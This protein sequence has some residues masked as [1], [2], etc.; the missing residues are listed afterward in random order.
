MAA[1]L[2][3]AGNIIMDHAFKFPEQE[4][5]IGYEKQIGA[6]ELALQSLDINTKFIESQLN[7]Q[8]NINQLTNMYSNPMINEREI[9]ESFMEKDE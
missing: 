1:G 9:M 6:A 5:R 2:K 7:A 3:M 4:R 8:L